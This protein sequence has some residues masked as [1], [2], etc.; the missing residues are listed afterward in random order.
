MQDGPVPD[1]G[2]RVRERIHAGAHVPGPVPGRCPPDRLHIRAHRA[3]RVLC[4]TRHVGAHRL[5]RAPRASQTR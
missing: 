3:Q 4:H 1:R 5:A 2:H